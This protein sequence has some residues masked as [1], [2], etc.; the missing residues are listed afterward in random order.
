MPCFEPDD[1]QLLSLLLSSSSDGGGYGDDVTSEI[2]ERLSGG[3]G[4]ASSNNGD[5]AGRIR[6]DFASS[7]SSSSASTSQS[8][9]GTGRMKWWDG[10]TASVESLGL[11]PPTQ[12]STPPPASSSS[13]ASGSGND[14]PPAAFQTEA[15][16][17]HLAAVC[18]LLDVDEARA[19]G[20]TL[21]TLR[22]LADR[23]DD[24]DA[25]TSA[26]S[27]NTGAGSGDE[28]GGEEKKDDDGDDNGAAAA[29]SSSRDS[30]RP[31]L[32][33][34][35]GTR[36]LLTSVRSYHFAQKLARL[37][38]LAECLR[39]DSSSSDD[40]DA[41]GDAD[42]IQDSARSLL[43]ELDRTL[44]HSSP[45][46][47]EGKSVG[48][49]RGLFQLLLGVATSSSSSSTSS[50]TAAGGGGGGGRIPTREELILAMKLRGGE[51]DAAATANT[52]SV[53]SLSAA[54]SSS[55]SSSSTDF[56]T[57]ANQEIAAFA[58]H[59]ATERSEA[60]EALLVLL[61][62]RMDGGVN[63]Y[64][65]GILMLAL[66]NRAVVEVGQQNQQRQQSSDGSS[67]AAA[68]SRWTKLAA[69]VVAEVAALWRATS[70]GEGGGGSSSAMSSGDAYPSW[71]VDHPLL[72]GLASS[73]ADA[74]KTAMAEFT[75]LGKI[76]R[77]Y[78]SAVHSR[79]ATA[80]A[81]AGTAS[82][83]PITAA[84]EAP[85][86]IG[87]LTYGLLL[88]LAGSACAQNSP[89]E[90]T[91]VA[92]T[93]VDSGTQYVTAAM[94]E[95]AAFDYLYDV[96]KALL[97]TFTAELINKTTTAPNDEDDEFPNLPGEETML[98]TDGGDS[99]AASSAAAGD[100]DATLVA[101]ASIGRE[102]LAGTVAAFRT[103]LLSS[104]ASPDNLEMLCNLAA[105][106]YRNSTALCDAFWSEWEVYCQERAAAVAAP[107]ADPI[108]H[109]LDAAFIMASSAL[110]RA[111]SPPTRA[112]IIV[113]EGQVCAQALPSVAPFLRLLS[114]LVPAV[115]GASTT[116][117]SKDIFASFLP[118]RIVHTVLVGC[119]GLC[120]DDMGVVPAVDDKTR[121]GAVEAITALSHL[122]RISARRDDDC[123]PAL[124]L[125][126]EANPS[127]QVDIFVGPRLLHIIASRAATI[128]GGGHAWSGDAAKLSSAAI[129]I[130]ADLVQSSPNEVDWV[131]ACCQRYIQSRAGVGGF[132]AFQSAAAKNCTE[133]LCVLA[134][135]QM[136][137]SAFA[138]QMDQL[139]FATT[140][141]PSSENVAS[142][143]ISTIGNGLLIACDVLTSTPLATAES[144]VSI[145]HDII[146]A[147]ITSLHQSLR[148]IGE[149]IAAH[150]S[151]TVRDT[152]KAVRDGIINYISTSTHVG[153][154]IAYYA[155][156]PVSVSLV[157]ELE[158]IAQGQS[159]FSSGS[160]E[161]NE[162][163][164]DSAR[165]YGA[166]AKLARDADKSSGAESMPHTLQS[167][168]ETIVRNIHSLPLVASPAGQTSS[169]VYD[170]SRSALA[171]I[172]QWGE[173]VE[174]MTLERHGYASS[175]GNGLAIEDAA[176][177]VSV[178]TGKA[179]AS[180][181]RSSSPFQLLLSFAPN[182]FRPSSSIGGLLS[183]S[184]E[185]NVHGALIS[186]LNLL[187]RYLGDSTDSSISDTT[188]RI[189]MMSLRHADA[190]AALSTAGQQSRPGD[191][192]VTKALGG[193]QQM[194][195]SL[196]ALLKFA[197][198][199]SATHRDGRLMVRASQMIKIVT[200]AVDTQPAL[201]RA[202]FMGAEVDGGNV[203]NGTGVIKSMSSA[204]KTIADAAASGNASGLSFDALIVASS[205]LDALATLWR[206]SRTRGS[207]MQK[208]GSNANK[209]SEIPLLHPCDDIIDVII[210]KT[211]IV[212]DCLTLLTNQQVLLGALSAHGGRKAASLKLDIC[213]SALEVLVNE[214]FASLR[215][216]GGGSSN[217]AIATIR[218][219]I[220]ESTVTGW[221]SSLTSLSGA[222]ESAESLTELLQYSN[223]GSS[224]DASRFV[225]LHSSPGK[226]DDR[227]SLVIRRAISTLRKV[228]NRKSTPRD[229]GSNLEL[230]ERLTN[231]YYAE[232]LSHSQLLLLKTWTKFAEVY[233]STT[234]GRTAAAAGEKV[235]KLLS[236]AD[237][238]LSSLEQNT[239]TASTASSTSSNVASTSYLTGKMG[240]H[241]TSL[242]AN[243]LGDCS[244][245]VKSG[246]SPQ[247][248]T[249]LDMLSRLGK[250]ATTLF[251]IT[252]PIQ[253]AA[254]GSGEGGMGNSAF[255]IWAQSR[256]Y[257]VGCLLR[258][259]ILTCS[260]SLLSMI[261][262]GPASSSGADAPSSPNVR[263]FNGACKTFVVLA[264]EA[265]AELRYAP[266]P[267]E[268]SVLG[269]DL[270]AIAG[271][272]PFPATAHFG[273]AFL[274]NGEGSKRVVDS[275]S[276]VEAVS[277]DGSLALS[278]LKTSIATLVSIVSSTVS[279]SS[280]SFSFQA[281][282]HTQ[283][284]ASALHDGGA[285]ASMF[286]HLE[287]ASRVAATSYSNKFS[288]PL[289]KV[290]RLAEENALDIIQR[291]VAFLEHASSCASGIS[292]PTLLVEQHTV[293]VL[294]ENPLLR[295]ACQQW[296][297]KSLSESE[298][299]KLLRGY[300]T[301]SGGGAYGQDQP[302]HREDP[303]QN[304]WRAVLRSLTGLL[305]S[306]R[307]N[308]RSSMQPGQGLHSRH[309]ECLRGVV[310]FLT[311]FDA[312]IVSGLQS[313]S[314]SV[315]SRSSSNP[316]GGGRRSP[317]SLGLIRFT[318][319]S[320]T[321]AADTLALISEL[322]TG[323]HRKYLESTSLNLYQALVSSAMNVS[324]AL[325]CFL[326]ATATA[327]ETFSCLTIIDKA[328]EEAEGNAA[329]NAD[330]SINESTM[331]LYSVSEIHPLVSE[332]V[333][334]AR[335][336]AVRY[337]HF[338]STCCVKMTSEEYAV[339]LCPTTKPNEAPAATNT[340]VA[341]TTTP[342]DDDKV[343]QSFQI[344]VDNLF[345][346]RM[347]RIAAECMFSSL[348]VLSKA[349]PAS[350]SFVY[351][352][353]TEASKLDA[354]SLVQ[355]GMV[356]AL[357][358]TSDGTTNDSSS[359]LDFVRVVDA[360]YLRQTWDV[361]SYPNGGIDT[362][363]RVPSLLL[364]GMEDVANRKC[365]LQYAPA[366]KLIADE[367]NLA[368]ENLSTG[369][370]I[371]ALRWC[372][373]HANSKSEGS[374]HSSNPLVRCL[375]GRAASLLG[376]E[377]SLHYELGTVGSTDHDAVRR[378]NAQLLELF[379]EDVIRRL[380]VASLYSGEQP[381]MGLRTVI[382]A[383]VWNAVVAELQE[384]LSS[385]RRDDEAFL[386]QHEE[387][388]GGMY[389][390]W[391]G[392]A[393]KQRMSPF[394]G[395][396]LRSLSL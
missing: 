40:G 352:T 241:L 173:H 278:L 341:T 304:I 108:C 281:T 155:A 119:V 89:S 207:G 36:S 116:P 349:H 344:H 42:A 227:V 140:S 318:M 22:M 369:H 18:G 133:N 308:D 185:S 377:V 79:V 321:E 26:D 149:I 223:Q 38:L 153:N 373:Q 7:S 123:G 44:V 313:C 138:R 266:S 94:D 257:R 34:L 219:Q 21:A 141:S 378:V 240:C 48:R 243:I 161:A 238:I 30:G 314:L 51:D 258:L 77:G 356:I 80:V 131:A 202:F 245:L 164:D 176:G 367:R 395:K 177:V 55:L 99:A 105:A 84:A 343:E 81:P 375:A 319:C 370:L 127:S 103:I 380:D 159:M 297:A 165:K 392:S 76:V 326:G 228:G 178:A 6:S 65:Y 113:N 85:E 154:A 242:L 251:R 311:V 337:A 59:S 97:P 179:M 368:L 250:V 218:S 279:N 56:R 181:L 390:G 294:A 54:S 4:D 347:E 310:Q 382:D 335:H 139:A 328:M 71:V 15:G 195:R 306:F 394:R 385:G 263:L 303:A 115:G 201:A 73:N 74:S 100:E 210:D 49:K 109:L 114:S 360:D 208:V 205:C 293:R 212:D 285:I 393:K 330:A 345:L 254:S 27:N 217:T 23:H 329:A 305:N 317:S 271:S 125:S 5:L 83:S 283:R 353:S 66:G 232:K 351:F 325:S 282:Q 53:F 189:V 168:S 338:A 151:A 134:S 348:N 231:Y 220:S 171:L 157:M 24:S 296:H 16:R 170:I 160:G 19:V 136:L 391:G 91:E 225:S 188:A 247:V 284:I 96:L 135:S 265:L 334:T 106:V 163:E 1:A 346:V 98:L 63:R 175:Y 200:L 261:D 364:A 143:V 180:D 35:L 121:Q 235:D 362:K 61:Y 129:D 355:L 361:E 339:S 194:H 269:T 244:E 224:I 288:N 182:P 280:D 167:F 359:T 192:S 47:P 248:E 191:V 236:S 226:L 12:V 295:I 43:D 111:W 320:L 28:S 249:L 277:L 221:A 204:I 342:K 299:E 92:Q 214:I 120:G 110:G 10:L 9:S 229:G 215:S 374:P 8:G 366:Q 144:S 78:A 298:D 222:A 95:C 183:F 166:W 3:G 312:L 246:E 384:G 20:L 274:V 124:R 287:A 272:I 302:V 315:A 332:G 331:A 117:S 172:L 57:Y 33:T 386:K 267:E 290:N 230:A 72:E 340:N 187:S 291:V 2:V 260:L 371:L 262:C 39:L 25:T 324:K 174:A 190:I 145:H 70:G 323:E 193:G 68:A 358:K 130:T 199:D 147:V 209:N 146:Y 17:A 150:S 211:T 128:A 86:A 357:R 289:Y 388:S 169:K 234:D 37:R 363:R 29:S 137:L 67:T 14:D 162:D 156:L 69:L 203:T 379:D 256:A 259:R 148:S 322:F 60:M 286:R 300:L 381:S 268:A 354:M 350:N 58:D 275:A 273:Y 372:R 316:L 64:D 389:G 196:E 32:R 270:H 197:V 122:I 309:K 198:D 216:D 387:N 62:D 118:E 46:G 88:R 90:V 13:F 31:T 255:M 365:L 307:I 132:A 87:L 142:E 112:G 264:S 184:I 276:D 101:Y 152:A 252:M 104:S 75:A 11:S 292:L 126:L 213:S 253:L 301:V 206:T 158:R 396:L 45:S 82:S 239:S 52:A 233:A 107:T 237:S 41:N 383:D 336:D 376:L 93:L 186:N 327:R 50:S 333:P 102:V